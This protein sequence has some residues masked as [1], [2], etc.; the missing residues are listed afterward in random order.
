LKQAIDKFNEEFASIDKDNYSTS[1][2]RLKQ[3]FND[4]INAIKEAEATVIAKEKEE[5]NNNNDNDD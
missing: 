4:I 2:G 3:M 5:E 1:K